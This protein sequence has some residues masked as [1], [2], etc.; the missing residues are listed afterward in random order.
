M[1]IISIIF[2]ILTFIFSASITFAEELQVDCLN[3]QLVF[4]Q[5][6]E[7]GEITTVKNQVTYDTG[8]W[9]VWR[10]EVSPVILSCKKVDGKII[11]EDKATISD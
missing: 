8:R 9:G 1:K 10:Y 2:T 3:G 6:L 5:K 7:S 4:L 11:V